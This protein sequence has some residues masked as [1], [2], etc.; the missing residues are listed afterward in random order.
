MTSSKPKKKHQ[1]PTTT[2][3]KLNLP[4]PPKSTPT[5]RTQKV[6]CKLVAKINK[7]TTPKRKYDLLEKEDDDRLEEA[8]SRKRTKHIH[9]YNT[10]IK[11]ATEKMAM[12]ISENVPVNTNIPSNSETSLE[13]LPTEKPATAT[14]NKEPSTVK[15]TTT[16]DNTHM[17][18][19]VLNLFPDED[20]EDLDEEVARLNKELAS[21]PTETPKPTPTPTPVPTTT[22]DVPQETIPTKKEEDR[23]QPPTLKSIVTKPIESY[24]THKE[25]SDKTYSPQPWHR[26]S[27]QRP[28]HRQHHQHHPQH[29]PSTPV[30][31]APISGMMFD[32]FTMVNRLNHHVGEAMKHAMIQEGLLRRNNYHHRNY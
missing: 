11:R 26:P 5:E 6:I 15:S 18:L 25:R 30:G 16:T 14:K 32:L 1:H 24:R 2:P 22:K 9:P 21:T 8:I 12:K 10:I 4:D 17:T 23:E 20:D 13:Q 29:Q 7:K 19:D 28:Q 31:Y 3:T 27:N